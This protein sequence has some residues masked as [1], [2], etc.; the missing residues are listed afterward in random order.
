MTS[1]AFRREMEELWR[2]ANQDAKER[3]DPFVA[4]EMLLSL[5]SDFDPERRECAKQVLATWVLSDAEAKRFDAMALIREFRIAEAVPALEKLRQQ[6]AASRAP[7]APFE[8]EKVD[9]L[10]AELR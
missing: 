4:L 5:Y 8:R 9:G 7:G 2:R 6:L 3:K 10:L 1:E